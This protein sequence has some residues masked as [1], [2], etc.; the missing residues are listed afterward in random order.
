MSFF[1]DIAAMSKKEFE[2]FFIS[3]QKKIVVNPLE[4]FVKSRL[5]MDT[6]PTPGQRVLLK[7]IFRQ[8]LDPV[9]KY[10]V[11][12]EIVDEKGEF[13]LQFILMTEV[14]LY[15]FFTE[16]TYVFKELT[17][18]TD[19]SLIVGRRGGK[20]LMSSILALYGAVM[21]NWKP[22]L[23]KHNTAT[24]LVMS[25][26]KEFSDEVID[27]VR[28]LIEESPV[29]HRLI[30]TA[31]KNTQSTINLKMPFLGKNGKIVYSRV[32]IRTNAASSR[33][34]RG[35]ACPVILAD[36]IAFWGSDPNSKET[37]AQIIAAAKPSMFQFEEKAML[38]KLSSP[39]IKHGV[40][41]N[42]F[43]MRD[44]LPGSCLVL[45]S[46]SWTFNSQLPK[47]KFKEEWELAQKN[48]LDN[49]ESEYR[50]NFVDST[51]IFIRSEMVDL[52]VCKGVSFIA[53][54]EDPRGVTDIMYTAAIDAAFKGDRFAFTVVSHNGTK[55][56]QHVMM[57]WAGTRIAPVKAHVIAKFIGKICLNFNLS[58]VHADQYAYQ[59]LR[60]I[61]DQYGINLLENTFTPTYKK[62]IYFNLKK[63]IHNQQLD[64][65]DHADQ[66]KE[67]K[68]LQVEQTQT[69]N[70][71]IGHPAGG[72]DDCSDATA[73]AVYEAVEN[74]GQAQAAG[75][76]IG[77]GYKIQKDSSGRAFTAP[78]ATMLGSVYQR[79]IE[80]NSHILGTKWKKDPETGAWVER[81]RRTLDDDL[82]G[83]E[84]DDFDDDAM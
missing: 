20:T 16:K 9:T 64:L 51:S 78:D 30:D 2:S 42:Y 34:T 1:E 28:A 65:L 4:N 18:L 80:D 82:Y 33:S 71:K 66:T 76:E 22:M 41:W 46:P 13:D 49:F 77:K 84:D 57:T 62:Q 59:P 74:S 72:T 43:S 17:S 10:N 5:F 26:T 45:K 61:F 37:D 29:M 69:G 79:N 56:R 15:E 14:E 12:E 24:M 27:V 75:D 36:E 8:E 3:L 55:I 58:E 54:E 35:S 31:K 60:E 48:P 83:E 25:H 52:C 53:P 63:T 23:G 44:S 40:L 68:Q 21:E 38:I 81:K 11:Y 7:L 6:K 39:G 73:I 32:R 50:A 19:I 70:I 47:Y 67:I